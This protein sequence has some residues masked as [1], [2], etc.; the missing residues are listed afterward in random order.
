MTGCMELAQSDCIASSATSHSDV[1]CVESIWTIRHYVMRPMNLE[2]VN[3]SDGT[4]GG[5]GMG[6]FPP[7]I[8]FFPP[9]SPPQKKSD[10]KKE[11]SYFVGYI[12]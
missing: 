10:T 4:T 6:Y 5:R 9:A 1:Q 8:F 12:T 11:N 3:A 7:E 2:M